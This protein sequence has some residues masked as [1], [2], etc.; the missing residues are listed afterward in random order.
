[1]ASILFS[2]VG[3]QD[4]VSHNTNEEGSIVTLVRYLLAQQKTIK[5]IILLYT[6]TTAKG[7]EETQEWLLDILEN[8][9]FKPE[10]FSLIQVQ[11]KL[12]TDPVNLSLVIEEVKTQIKKI[13]EIQKGDDILELNSSSGTPT[14]KASLGVLQGAG[15]LPKSNIWQ[16]RN[17]REM[18]EGQA[19]VFK[20]NVD[21]LK[22]EFDI[23]VIKEQVS[24]YNY[25][26]ALKTL[27]NSSLVDN[28][29]G[30]F[31]QYGAYRLAFNFK[32]ASEYIRDF[33]SF[34]EE[35]LTKEINR[36]ASKNQESI[37]I[38]LYYHILAHL[39]T[40]EYSQFLILVFGF[41]EFVLK[42][43]VR[44]FISPDLLNK[45]WNQNLKQSVINA[46]NNYEHGELRK[47]VQKYRQYNQTLQID[48]MSRI[49]MLRIIQYPS[50]SCPK[51][52]IDN[53]L[54][55]ESYCD[56][57][58]ELVH[59]FEGVSESDITETEL[60]DMVNKIQSIL[61]DLF[62]DSFIKESCFAVLNKKIMAKLIN[63][64]G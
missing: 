12:S 18:R 32:D 11:E 6:E 62:P 33:R 17:P 23:K 56:K 8:S 52:L 43:L 40:K 63:S 35:R 38:E 28:G 27:S 53:L 1:M 16:V 55:L 60:N 45:S 37:L 48:K 41:Q 25:N 51:S 64:D 46:C 4:P 31:L 13:Q 22:Q 58:N 50:F 21:I 24:N 47:Y 19:R 57:R 54:H 15:Y 59:Q 39:K 9:P 44:K 30:Y 5:K 49:V 14:M 34:F 36:L 10:D 42:F 26:G 3:N 20:T 61:S 7:A 29:I 2:F